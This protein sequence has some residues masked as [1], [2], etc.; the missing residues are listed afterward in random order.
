MSAG[1]PE[2]RGRL[3]GYAA[4]ELAPASRSEVRAHLR[5]C[6]DCRREA[7]AADPTLLFAALPAEPVSPRDVDSILGAVRVGIALKESE[8]RIAAGSRGTGR[9]R[10]N[11]ARIAAVAAV[12]LATLGL[13]LVRAPKPPERPAGA[14]RLPA[15]G[16]AA[17]AE[18]PAK[19]SDGAT[20]YDWN[21]G[22]GEPRVVWIVDGSL[23]I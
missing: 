11:R 5:S 13:P 7:G 6:S 20:V 19:A 2:I 18:R 8:R 22:G 16:F 15:A 17:A 14:E 9:A 23:D 21:P 12:V 1:C 10:G 3:A 4:E